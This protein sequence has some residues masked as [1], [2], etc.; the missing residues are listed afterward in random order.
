M[1]T[2]GEQQASWARSCNVH[3]LDLRGRENLGCGQSQRSGGWATPW[4]GSSIQ[5]DGEMFQVA[6]RN[7]SGGEV[8]GIRAQGLRMG[9]VSG[10]CVGEGGEKDA[11]GQLHVMIW[12]H[13]L[14]FNTGNIT[15]QKQHRWVNVFRKDP[16]PELTFRKAH[17]AATNRKMDQDRVKVAISFHCPSTGDDYQQRWDVL[18]GIWPQISNDLICPRT[19]RMWGSFRHL[20]MFPHNPKL[21]LVQANHSQFL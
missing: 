5:V 13:G 15:D 7:V 17:V 11:M 16:Q 9:A 6:G 19:S 10:S 20:R 12:H 14:S 3:I 21:S 2:L 18:S 1:R 4:A 8:L